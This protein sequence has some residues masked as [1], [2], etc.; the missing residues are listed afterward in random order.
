ML[1]VVLGL[2]GAGWSASGS[3]ASARSDVSAAGPAV[4][5]SMSA[6]A[7]SGGAEAGLRPPHLR[8]LAGAVLL[9]ALP[10]GAQPYW[11][12]VLGLGLYFSRTAGRTRLRPLC[13]G[14][15]HATRAPPVRF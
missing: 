6:A 10:S 12:A 15:R 11:V 7:T 5:H 13:C 1:A 2:G 8:L 3:P 14:S 4:D 9:T